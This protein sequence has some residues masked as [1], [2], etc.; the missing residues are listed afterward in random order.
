MSLNPRLTEWPGRVVW[1]IGASSGIG[2]A[3][4][5]RL[6]GLGAQ[7]VVSARNRAALEA[8]VLEHPGSRALPM[9]VTDAAQV[10]AATQALCAGLVP[11]VVCYCAGHYKAMR[12][13]A[14]DLA[15]WQRHRSVNLDGAI[16]VLAAVTAPLLARGWGHISLVSSVAG[17]R[18]LPNSL[19]YGPTKAALTHLA[20]VLYLDLRPRG[21]G[22]SVI[23]PGFVAT[24]LTARNDFH[25]PAMIS[26][27]AAAQAIVAGWAQGDFMIDFPRR[28]TRVLALLRLLPYRLY[29][30]LVHRATGL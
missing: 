22:V 12:A 24:P 15:E 1:V 30:A 20:E 29:F 9:D 8:F 27:E 13:D 7:V 14:V 11:H 28:F 17:H 3:L 26:P 18:G 2:R 21:I 23:T 6:H 10:A 16:N 4:A 5:A 19:A 25:M